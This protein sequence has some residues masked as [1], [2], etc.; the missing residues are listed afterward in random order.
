[1]VISLG[2]AVVSQFHL[3]F[4][5]GG[6]RLSMGFDSTWWNKQTLLNPT[7]RTLCF[8]KHVLLAKQPATLTASVNARRLVLILCSLGLAQDQYGSLEHLHYG[9]AAKS[10]T[11]H[12]KRG[13]PKSQ[14]GRR[15]SLFG[16][17]QTKGL[18]GNGS[19]AWICA[20]L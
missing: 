13:L 10:R 11:P 2:F 16:L 20:G 6:G 3:W 18:W 9:P 5:A 15:Q 7:S 19:D 17:R 8:W 1:M 12:L 14:H 4:L